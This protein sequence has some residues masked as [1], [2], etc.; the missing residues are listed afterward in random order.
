M[1]GCSRAGEAGRR[2]LWR[3]RAELPHA[4]DALSRE[5][6]VPDAAR[7]TVLPCPADTTSIH[8][9]RRCVLPV[10]SSRHAC[11]LSSPSVGQGSEATLQPPQSLHGRKVPNKRAHRDRATPKTVGPTTCRKTRMPDSC[12]TPPPPPKLDPARR[13]TSAKSR[14]PTLVPTATPLQALARTI[15]P[16]EDPSRPGPR[17][18][19]RRA[20]RAALPSRSTSP[21]RPGVTPRRD[22]RDEE[23]RRNAS[24]PAPCRR[25]GRLAGRPAGQRRTPCGARVDAGAPASSAR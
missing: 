6:V 7:T 1:V 23:A 25:E 24:P 13:T 21:R 12:M 22:A 4:R 5:S 10:S 8:D 14:M 9:T 11:M 17:K 19:E 16:P 3:G 20:K 15:P 2:D 18:R